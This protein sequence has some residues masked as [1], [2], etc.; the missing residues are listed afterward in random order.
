M[1]WTP[2]QSPEVRDGVVRFEWGQGAAA[3]F[4]GDIDASCLGIAGTVTVEGIGVFHLQRRPSVHDNP[5]AGRWSA[6][7]EGSQDDGL[8]V[9]LLRQGEAWWAEVDAPHPSTPLKAYPGEVRTDALSDGVLLVEY[10]TVDGPATIALEPGPT[11]LSAL[12][13]RGGRQDL[14]AMRR[15]PITTALCAEPGLPTLRARFER[16]ATPPP[17]PVAVLIGEPGQGVVDETALALRGAGLAT[18][19]PEFHGEDHVARRR[20]LRRWMTWLVDQAGVDHARIVLVGHGSGS[21]TA[22]RQAASFGDPIAA[23]VLL[24]PPGVPGRTR[25]RVRIQAAMEGE[26]PA[27]ALEAWDTYV[28]YATQ[29]VHDAALAEA[30]RAWIEAG[31]LD[32]E[33]S[34]DVAIAHAMEVSRDADWLEDMAYDPRVGFSRIRGMPVLG[35]SGDR[36]AVFD[37]P[38]NLAALSDVAAT[39]SIA[40]DTHVLPGLDHG[41]KRARAR[42]IDPQ[43]AEVIVS[44]LADQLSLRDRAEPAP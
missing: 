26:D 7:A 44:W 42:S 11:E 3:E 6:V 27:A 1:P 29:G 8:T 39:R 18:L 24:S 14:I 4:R 32:A 21:S 16:P 31:P 37:G 22:T 17:H 13:T 34:T 5:E 15:T 41:L 19:V 10:P 43:A 25:M 9:Y 23:L 20:A 36:N 28:R 35:V 40:L 12:W 38:A 30:A 33:R 2:L